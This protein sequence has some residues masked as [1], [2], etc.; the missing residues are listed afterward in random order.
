MYR[1]L[2]VTA[3]WSCRERA[4]QGEYGACICSGRCD[5]LRNAW[6]HVCFSRVWGG[7]PGHLWGRHVL[8]CSSMQTQ[9]SSSGKQVWHV[10]RIILYPRSCCKSHWV[11]VAQR[12]EEQ[13]CQPTSVG[14]HRVEHTVD[15][16]SWCHPGAPRGFLP[17]SVFSA[18]RGSLGI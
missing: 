9:A 12:E 2:S 6:E 15:P 17:I 4:C 18:S 16:S 10:Y 3:G 11:P 14:S 13:G 1:C 7:V 8:V 5:R